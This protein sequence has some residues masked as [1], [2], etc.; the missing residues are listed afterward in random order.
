MPPGTSASAPTIDLPAHLGAI[1]TSELIDRTKAVLNKGNLR[2]RATA[3]MLTLRSEQTEATT[4]QLAR[5]AA[6]SRD[7]LVIS[8]AVNLCESKPA[9]SGLARTWTQIEPANAAAWLA[10]EQSEPAASA[11]VRAGLVAAKHFSL[12]VGALVHE[13]MQAV[14]TDAAPYLRFQLAIL[15]IGYDIAASIPNL[16]PLMALCTPVPPRGSERQATCSAVATMVTEHSDT[17]LGRAI[18]TRMGERAGW[19]ASRVA[20]LRAEE[21]RLNAVMYESPM[22][23]EQ[24]MSC[25]SVERVMRFVQERGELGELAY[26]RKKAAPQGRR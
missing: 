16:R 5:L 21:N 14:P 3:L 22:D 20:E 2:Q 24:P 6:A 15:F 17:V 4:E 10:L 8:W 18:G 19:P 23:M 12:R 26:L 1:P 7:S 25:K 13:A 9:C 11:E